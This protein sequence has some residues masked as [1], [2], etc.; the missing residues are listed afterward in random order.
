VGTYDYN[1]KHLLPKWDGK[2][3]KGEYVTAGVYL[4]HVKTKNSSILKKMVVIR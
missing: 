2:N 4:Y 1:S 3:E